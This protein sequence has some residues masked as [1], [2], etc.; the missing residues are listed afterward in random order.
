MAGAS[1]VCPSPSPVSVS[2]SEVLQS[3]AVKQTGTKMQKDW[4]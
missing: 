2:S 4:L 3:F 1:V